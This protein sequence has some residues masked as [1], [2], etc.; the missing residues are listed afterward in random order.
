MNMTGRAGEY[1]AH[2]WRGKKRID[3]AFTLIVLAMTLLL[4]FLPTGYEKKASSSE[5][6]KALV[7]ETD[8]AMVRN[9]GIVMQGEQ[10]VK[11]RIL[12]G[13]FKGLEA[14][15]NNILYGKADLDKLFAPGDVALA[16]IDPA[17]AKGAPP[18][19]T[20][21]DQYRLGIE[22]AMVIAFFALLLLYGGWTGA[23]SAAAFLFAVAAIWKV[24]I[25]TFLS[26]VPPV[27]ASLGTVAVLSGVIILLV[28]G[29]T[30]TGAAAILGS[31]AG[32]A[33]SAAAALLLAEPYHVNGAVRPFAETLLYGGFDHL[34]LTKIFLAGTFLASSGAFIDLAMDIAASMEEV[35]AKRPEL[36]FKDLVFSGLTVGRKIIGT[37]TTTLLLAYTGGYTSLLMVFMAQGV[38]MA[39]MFNITYVSS[40][41]FHTMIG[42]LGLLTIAPFTALAAGALFS[43]RCT[44]APG[45]KLS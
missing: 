39:N 22:G 8:D 10:L 17:A 6:A 20:L 44:L 11:V 21:M 40:E 42:S 35:H 14:D 32:T 3:V 34:N 12:G 7:L 27:L 37:E 13:A 16:V 41:I 1:F 30:R 2:A 33:V 38:P 28:A 25:P 4:V 15:A 26:G 19:I 31:L 43:A 29:F 5:R 45:A 9:F 18:V 36:G 24:L 23:R